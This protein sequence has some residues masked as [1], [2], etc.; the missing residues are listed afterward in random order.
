MFLTDTS[1]PLDTAALAAPGRSAHSA[2]ATAPAVTVAAPPVDLADRI[3]RIQHVAR[4]LH[5]SVDRARELTY[6]LAFPAPGAGFSRNLWSR[7]DGV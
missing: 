6:S 2:S 7:T 5:L 1:A 4:A 3:W